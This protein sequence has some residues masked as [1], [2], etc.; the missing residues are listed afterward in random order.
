MTNKLIACADPERG[1]GGPD[2]PP[3]N[4]K[5][6]PK[7]GNFRIFGGLD[8]PPPSS[9]T[10]N[11]HFRW[12]PSHENFWIR[13]WIAFMLLFISFPSC[14]LAISI[15]KTLNFMVIGCSPTSKLRHFFVTFFSGLH[16]KFYSQISKLYCRQGPN[17]QNT[18]LIEHSFRIKIF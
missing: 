11:Y 14:L 1:T 6:L 8:P 18:L 2:P 4:S 3:W 7:K 10:K 5:I 12:T 13:A 15:T 17:I 9:V 16:V